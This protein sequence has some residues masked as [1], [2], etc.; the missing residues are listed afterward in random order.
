MCTN[1]RKL[2]L[3]ALI[4]IYLGTLFSYWFGHDTNVDGIKGLDYLDN[5]VMV[6]GLIVCIFGITKWARSS[7]FFMI[8]SITVLLAQV[9]YLILWNLTLA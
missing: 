9:G 8:G 5:F 2:A 7:I 6:I 3:L 1:K 4:L